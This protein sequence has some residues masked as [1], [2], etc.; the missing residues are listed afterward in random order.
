MV[1]V[2]IKAAMHLHFS[3]MPRNT[4]IWGFFMTATAD[5]QFMAY[6]LKLAEKGRG[7]TSP[8]PLVGAVI[9]KNDKVIAT[10]YHKAVGKDHAEISAIKN[11]KESVTGAT[12]YVN[13]EPC[14]HIGRTGPCTDALIKNKIKRVVV[15]IKDPN[16][17]VNGKGIRIL[18]KAGIEVT[19]NVLT[20]ES[21][22]INDIYIHTHTSNKPFVILKLAQTLDGK[23]AT[24]TGESKYLSCK[25]SLEFV[26]KLRSEV[27]A[28]VIGSQTALQD[29]PSL[30]VRHIK[31]NNPYRILLSKTLKN[32]E[33]LNMIAENK[34]FKTIVA[35]ISSSL[36][37]IETLDRKLITWSIKSEKNLMDL[38]DFLEKAKNFNI[39]SILC[40]GGS[41][42]ASSLLTQK[43]VDKIILITVPKIMGKGINSF[44]TFNAK[45]LD[46]MIIFKKHYNFILGDDSIFV[47]YPNWEKA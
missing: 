44:S 41:K 25:K 20:D 1:E 23:I 2:F 8:N 31:G 28:V 24:L 22:Y 33:S 7:K 15:G 9:V 16:P 32:F 42:L 29:N 26:H 40:E 39:N 21:S 45:T 5:T 47:G 37:K 3:A 4:Y 38:T 17:L 10:G 34:D 13:L 35:S 19:V 18:R 11:A 6:A 46:E 43:L 30:T 27:D 14:C 36:K 12:L